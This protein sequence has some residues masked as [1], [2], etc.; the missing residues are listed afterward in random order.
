MKDEMKKEELTND[1]SL[2]E[3]EL[4]KKVGNYILTE[5]IGV[6]TFSKVTRGIHILTKEK[7]AVKILDKS[8][9]KDEIDIEHISRE[10]E[11]LKSISHKNIAQLYESIST[12]HNVYLIIEYIE[13]GDLSDFIAQNISLSENLACH[14]FR[15]LISVIEYLNDMG[16]THRDLKPEN[17]LLDS[18]HKNI[19]VIDFGL[20]NY[21]ANTELLKSA[22]G[23]PCFASPEMLSG[24]SYLGVTTDLWSAGIVLYSMLVGTLPFDDQEINSLYEHIKIGTFYIP[25][26]LSL[27]CIDFLKQILHIDPE[28]RITIEKIKKHPWFNL[29]KNIMYKGIDLTVKTFPYNEKLINYVINKYYTDDRDIT[30]ED[31]IKMIQYHACNQYTSTYYLAEKFFEK[32]KNLKLEKNA[33]KKFENIHASY[34]SSVYNKNSGIQFI[35]KNKKNIAK[36]LNKKGILYLTNITENINNSKTEDNNDRFKNLRSNKNTKE[37]SKN[38][39]KVYK[40]TRNDINNKKYFNIQNNKKKL[41]HKISSIFKYLNDIKITDNISRVKTPKSWSKKKKKVLSKNNLKGHNIYDKIDKNKNK[42]KNRCLQK[43]YKIAK[44]KNISDV[45]MKKKDLIINNKGVFPNSY[46]NEE[47]NNGKLYSNRKENLNKNT[48]YIF[49]RHKENLM[50]NTQKNCLNHINLSKY[51]EAWKDMEDKNNFEDSQKF[52]KMSSSKNKKRIYIETNFNSKFNTFHNNYYLTERNIDKI[53]YPE[54]NHSL[55]LIKK[56]CLDNKNMKNKKMNK[57]LN[58]YKNLIEEY[59]TVNLDNKK[60]KSKSRLAGE[61]FPDSI[62]YNKKRKIKNVILTESLYNKTEITNTQTLNNKVDSN[63]LENPVTLY[64]KNKIHS[65]IKPNNSKLSNNTLKQR[66]IIN[67]NLIDKSISNNDS[68]AK[69]F[70]SKLKINPIKDK[71]K[72]R[73][74]NYTSNINSKRNSKKKKDKSSRFHTYKKLSLSTFNKNKNNKTLD[75]NKII[76]ININ[77][78]MKIKKQYSFNLTKSRDEPSKNIKYIYNNN[79]N[80]RNNKI[81]H[82]S[83]PLSFDN[84]RRNKTRNLIKQYSRNQCKNIRHEIDNPKIDLDLKK[85]KNYSSMLK[86]HFLLEHL[87]KKNV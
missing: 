63:I 84:K 51:S 22:C 39:K 55:I 79:K 4:I 78:I 71:S 9:I 14:F 77:N 16:I 1:N 85:N 40:K 64:L 67:I 31:F 61:Y 60:D 72:E 29:E 83:I 82:N 41:S 15:Q 52:H 36:K 18:S 54:S 48:N 17:I 12:E 62:K 65:V 6:G 80:I 30:R 74:S 69:L 87:Y 73:N 38:K 23:S 81:N 11:I 32:N 3:K 8:K 58:K 42:N 49:S 59:N 35:E 37:N 2:S 19:K 53:Q 70:Y 20:S 47:K 13:G 57:S 10:I 76:N 66:K 24:K 56:K 28:K 44:D 25:S 33:L 27:K 7:V 50:C 45:N 68:I 26:N 75:N 5:Q 43:I 46:F 86:K 34:K 21:C